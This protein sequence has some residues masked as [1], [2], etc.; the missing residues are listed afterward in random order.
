MSYLISNER[1]VSLV[2]VII[3]I[4]ITVVGIISL[5]DLQPAAWRTATRSDH[6][7]RAAGVLQRQLETQELIIMNPCSAVAAGSATTNVRMSDQAGSVAG[8]ATYQVQ[9]T[10]TNLATNVWRVTITVSW[11]PLN[12][13]GI[14]ESI[15]VTR[16]E[17]FRFPA[18]CV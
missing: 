15:V 14:T 18:G 17:R 9:T 5:M 7:G 16:Q 2:E 3:A 10:I 4:F 13:T 11:P 8:D 1:G 6:L 12:N